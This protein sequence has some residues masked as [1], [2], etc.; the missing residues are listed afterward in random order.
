MAGTQRGGLLPQAVSKH[1]DARDGL[2]VTGILGYYFLLTRLIYAH[3]YKK[4]S[5]L[6]E[7]SY[8]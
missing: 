4:K 3:C 8:R 7:C 5:Q 1:D 6:H 2:V